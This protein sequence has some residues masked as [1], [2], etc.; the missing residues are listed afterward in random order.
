MTHAAE[1]AVLVEGLA[2]D[3][4][5]PGVSVGMLVDG[6][7]LVASAGVTSTKDPLPVDEDTL[8]MIGSTSKTFTATAVMAL[9]DQGALTLKDRVI[10]HLPGLV[11]QDLDVA[12][13]VT[14]GHLLNHT[15][16]WRGDLIT[17][18]SWNDDTLERALD[19]VAEAPQELPLGELASY[20]NSGFSLAGHLLATVH[21]TSF[22]QA[23]RELVLDPLGLSSSVYFPWDVAHRRH[24]VGHTVQDGVA[25]PVQIYPAGRALGPSGGLWSSVRDQLAWAAYHLDGSTDGTAPLLEETRLLMQ[26]PTIAS[27]ST[28]DGIGLSWLLK[29]HGDVTL[30]THGGNVSNLQTSAFAVAP[31]HGIAVT[32]LTTGKHGMTV[33]AKVLGWALDRFLGIGPQPEL[34]TIPF[35]AAELAGR[36]DL[37]P[38]CYLL[39]AEDGKLLSGLQLPDGLPEPVRI[40]FTAPPKE[41]VAIGPDVFALAGSPTEPVLDVRR[42]AD[43][44]VD[45]IVFGMR[46]VRRVP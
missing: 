12:Q 24:A 40:A 46:F 39:T 1:L 22:E 21:G 4:A 36:Y 14:V 15:G 26:Q 16:G 45:G 42:K 11:L 6:Q 35:D 37:G 5:I 3:L 17:P 38:Y 19:G 20:S 30:I 27:R 29:H 25:T 9:V 34:P 43:G 7:Q 31:A 32:A 28:I 41:L 2:A 13:S 33:G 23:V 8:F 44:T 18:P 10:D